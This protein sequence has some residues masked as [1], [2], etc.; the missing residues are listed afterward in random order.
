[1]WV[2]GAWVQ[3]ASVYRT[4][5]PKSTLE[6]LVFPIWRLKGDCVEGQLGKL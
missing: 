4:G 2:L 5:F 6:D 1:M 3:V